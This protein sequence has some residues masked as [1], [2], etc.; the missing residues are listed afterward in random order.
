[1]SIYIKNRYTVAAP[2]GGLPIY[3]KKEYQHRFLERPQQNMFGYMNTPNNVLPTFQFVFNGTLASFGLVRI[4]TVDGQNDGQVYTVP[5]TTGSFF[6]ICLVA[7]SDRFFY[8]K[9][10]ALSWALPAGF[11]YLRFQD[12]LKFRYSEVFQ[13]GATNCVEP[14]VTAPVV[15]DGP[16]GTVDITVAVL[17]TSGLTVVGTPQ[18]FTPSAPGGVDYTVIVQEDIISGSSIEVRIETVTQNFGTFVNRFDV[19]YTNPGQVVI[20]PKTA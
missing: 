1:M 11:Y 10:I 7:T 2:G 20:T 17:A 6:E 8:T 5:A 9:D 14:T 16:T 4:I 15:I 3:T 18:L 12:G 13:L 19:A